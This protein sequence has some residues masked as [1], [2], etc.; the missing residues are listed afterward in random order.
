[1]VPTVWLVRPALP[2]YHA[3][4]WSPIILKILLRVSSTALVVL[5]SCS[6]RI[7]TALDLLLIVG[8]PSG[9]ALFPSQRYPAPRLGGL[10]VTREDVGPGSSKSWPTWLITS[11]HRR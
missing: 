2:V 1:M 4:V 6:V 10:C 5:S 7:Y 11:S 9:E 8:C 3:P